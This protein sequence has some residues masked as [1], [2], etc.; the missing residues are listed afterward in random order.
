ME[1]TAAGLVMTK[2][3]NEVLGPEELR[4]EVLLTEEKW[5]FCSESMKTHLSGRGLSQ[6][7]PRQTRKPLEQAIAIE[8]NWFQRLH[9]F[10]PGCTLMPYE[11]AAS[12]LFNH[13]DVRS[14]MTAPGMAEINEICLKEEE[15]S[16]LTLL[17][18][19]GCRSLSTIWPWAGR[20]GTWARRNGAPALPLPISSPKCPSHTLKGNCFCNM[21]SLLGSSFALTYII[22]IVCAALQTSVEAVCRG[23]RKGEVLQSGHEGEN[24][25]RP[26]LVVHLCAQLLTA[27]SGTCRKINHST[28]T[29]LSH[30]GKRSL[31]LSLLS[32]P[33]VMCLSVKPF[34]LIRHQC[35]PDA[36]SPCWPQLCP[37]S[38]WSYSGSAH[39]C[40]RQ[41][42]MSEQL[43]ATCK[44]NAASPSCSLLS[45]HYTH[46][47]T[48]KID[49]ICSL[50]R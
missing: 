13:W 34:L 4:S 46:Y 30:C 44:G 47:K 38:P 8:G 28:D 12:L 37:E 20:V 9:L 25:L 36:A 23:E 32:F 24:S 29:S 33:S 21:A 39:R 2:Q 3:P 1:N 49:L 14:E 40:S 7:A 31:F 26:A 48:Q 15:I 16:V 27:D 19:W 45:Q 6:K 18:L 41:C 42:C 35:P 22:W 10:S 5:R 50:G 11:P 17:L 43:R